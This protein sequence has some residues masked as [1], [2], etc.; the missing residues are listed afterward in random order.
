MIGY[1]NIWYGKEVEGRFTDI[2]TCFIANFASL[3]YGTER[4]KPVPHIYICSPATQQLIDDSK[5]KDFN[6]QNVFNMITDTQFVSIEATPGMLERIPPMI[7]I[8][9]HILLMID[10]KDAGLLK[11]TDSIKVVYGDYKLYCTTVH[12]M[13]S[14]NPDDY[15]FDRHEV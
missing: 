4:I 7:R 12:N 8:R 3:V 13:Q 6:W 2:E 15:K 9:A 10:C 14:V 5:S 1:K 11:Q